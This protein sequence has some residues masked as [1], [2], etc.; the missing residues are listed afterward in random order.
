V[1][2]EGAFAVSPRKPIRV[3]ARTDGAAAR[4]EPGTGVDGVAATTA[5]VIDAKDFSAA[6]G[7]VTASGNVRAAGA[8][9]C[10]GLV[11][12]AGTAARTAAESEARDF[13]G[14]RGAATATTAAVTD[15]S[16]FPLARGDTSASATPRS[17]G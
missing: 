3:P 4:A 14:A 17:R 12:D 10:T 15:S 2:S 13:V 16:D 9:F 8:A 11:D 1:P 6:R 7:V 5:V